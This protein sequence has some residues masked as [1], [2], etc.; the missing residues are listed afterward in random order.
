[1]DLS[2]APFLNLP[3]SQA[4]VPLQA[5]NEMA[6]MVGMGMFVVVSKQYLVCDIATPDNTTN[7]S[8]HT[9]SHDMTNGTGAGH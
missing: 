5:M 1:M 3:L 4:F 2:Q 7:S 9:L 6:P 8:K